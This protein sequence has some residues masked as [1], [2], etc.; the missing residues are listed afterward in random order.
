MLHENPFEIPFRHIDRVPIA[1]QA[2][3]RWVSIFFAIPLLGIGLFLA[4]LSDNPDKSLRRVIIIPFLLL[5]VAFLYQGLFYTTR[6]STPLV[7]DAP[8]VWR[9]RLQKLYVFITF[10]AVISVLGGLHISNNPDA[11]ANDL[12]KWA[13]VTLLFTFFYSYCYYY[14]T[15]RLRA[16]GSAGKSRLTVPEG[17]P[18]KRGQSVAVILHCAGLPTITS[19]FTATLR[20]L[21]EYWIYKSD[22]DETTGRRTEVISEQQQSVTVTAEETSF[23]VWIDPAGRVTDYDYQAPTFWELEVRDKASG[24]YARFFLEVV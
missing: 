15:K 1:N 16:A 14:Y 3:G 21:R 19:D 20:N 13:L 4:S 23:S 5:S 12:L 10:S 7:Y 8:R 2:Y 18:V 24:Y 11:P 9:Q 17:L 22:D 6:P